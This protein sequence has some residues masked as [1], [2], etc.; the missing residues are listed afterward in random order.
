MLLAVRADQA[1]YDAWRTAI[2][3]LAFGV[4]QDMLLPECIIDA[5]SDEVD[6]TPALLYGSRAATLATLYM[7]GYGKYRDI[8][9]A[10]MV[11]MR[12]MP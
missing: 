7:L 6:G 2:E 8:V 11:E 4:D 3:Y 9:T 1:A 12:L 5:I 10:K